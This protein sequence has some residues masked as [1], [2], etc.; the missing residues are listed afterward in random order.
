VKRVEKINAMVVIVKDGKEQVKFLEEKKALFGKAANTQI[1]RK[2]II[3]NDTTE[4][5]GRR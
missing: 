4:I 5:I 1:I 2:N 3:E